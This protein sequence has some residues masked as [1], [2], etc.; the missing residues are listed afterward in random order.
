MVFEYIPGPKHGLDVMVLG[1]IQIG[2]LIKWILTT[3]VQVGCQSVNV[4]LG[5]LINVCKAAPH[6]IFL[7][8]LAGLE[9][10]SWRLQS[11]P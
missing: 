9:L 1:G 3:P 7:V 6:C 10:P 11:S 5:N 2:A 4:V 8:G